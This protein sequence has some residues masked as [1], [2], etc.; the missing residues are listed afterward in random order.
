VRSWLLNRQNSDIESASELLHS[1][2]MG[3]D[4]K[5][6]KISFV[7]EKQAAILIQRTVRD[8]LRK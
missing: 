1:A 3:S 2:F 5:N 8:W 7:D 4:S 6:K